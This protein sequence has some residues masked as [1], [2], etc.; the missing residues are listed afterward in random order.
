MKKILFALVLLSVSVVAKAVEHP[1][2]LI[3]NFCEHV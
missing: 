1:V 2:T 3:C